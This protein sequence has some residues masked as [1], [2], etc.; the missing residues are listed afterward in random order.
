M[1]GSEQIKRELPKPENG[2]EPSGGGIFGQR[3]LAC[4]GDA[5][6]ETRPE[7]AERAMIESN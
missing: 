3:Q 2:Q 7:H 4:V 1:T 6:L 5:L